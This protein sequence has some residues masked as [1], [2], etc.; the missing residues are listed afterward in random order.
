MGIVS[1]VQ[2]V[3]RGEVQ[4]A[5][6]ELKE[7]A[8]QMGKGAGMIGA[9]VF[10]GLI[11]FMFLMLGVTYFINQWLEMWL[12]ALIVG[13]VLVLIAAILAMV[14]KSQIQSANLKPEKTI[15]SVKEDKQWVNHQI[16]SVK[17]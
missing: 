10:F 4:L 16:K 6:T 15:E 12:S 9:G 8:T 13:A 11:G 14:G 1:D 2:N 17:K 5:K 3:I 7:D